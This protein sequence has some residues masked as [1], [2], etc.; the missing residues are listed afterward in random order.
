MTVQAEQATPLLD[1]VHELEERVQR[2]GLAPDEVAHERQKA[3]GGAEDARQQLRVFY[4]RGERDAKR[5]RALREALEAAEREADGRWHERLDGARMA[6]GLARDDLRAFIAENFP[7]L[8]A[9]ILP[10]CVVAGERFKTAREAYAAA[11]AAKQ[12]LLDEWA[13]LIGPA[14]IGLDDLPDVGSLEL[15][16]PRSLAPVAAELV[17]AGEEEGDS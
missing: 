9:E 6:E 17:A 8:T 4:A 2:A 13:V 1:R 16:V 15:P 11:L 12:T 3:L 7:R 14:G 5:E 10:G